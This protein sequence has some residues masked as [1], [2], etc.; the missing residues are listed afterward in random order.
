M[1]SEN[2][3]KSFSFDEKDTEFLKCLLSY[4]RAEILAQNR[5]RIH[6]QSGVIFSIILTIKK[7]LAII[8]LYNKMNIRNYLKQNLTLVTII[9]T[10]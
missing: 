6:I 7:I 1:N 10:L 3:E 8:Y 4:I 9:L 2:K 5:I